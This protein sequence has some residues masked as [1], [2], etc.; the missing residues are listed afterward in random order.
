MLA[1]LAD[2]LLSKLAKCGK[3]KTDSHICRNLHKT[4]K[5]FGRA[6]PVEISGVPTHLRLSRRRPQVPAVHPVLHLSSWAETIFD[7]GGHFFMQGCDLSHAAEFSIVLKQYWERFT[8]CTPEFSLP[9]S[10][11]GQSIP[12]ALHGDEGRGRLKQPVMVMSVQ[13]IL[14]LRPGKTNMAGPFRLN[15]R[16]LFFP[17]KWRY[18][19]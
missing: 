15:S 16:I 19:R 14:P 6:L 11:W 17:L 12:V 5:A 2:P 1:G 8:S 3:N 18:S 9:E 13:P 7:N 4:I 10:V